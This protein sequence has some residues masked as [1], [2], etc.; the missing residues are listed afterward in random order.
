M[1]SSWVGV[2]FLF[3][4]RDEPEVCVCVSILR[5]RRVTTNVRVLLLVLVLVALIV[6][7][8]H[9]TPGWRVPGWAGSRRALGRLLA[10]GEATKPPNDVARRCQ[11]RMIWHRTRFELVGN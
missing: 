10:G 11:E 7:C 2:S 5:E 6:W 4:L 9:G 3:R 8:V 1:P